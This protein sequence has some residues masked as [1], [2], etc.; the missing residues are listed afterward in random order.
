MT[1]DTQTRAG[2]T[3]LRQESGGSA[4]SGRWSSYF[5]LLS[6]VLIVETLITACFLFDFARDI[7]TTDESLNQGLYPTDCFYQLT[8]EDEVN[9]GGIASCELMKKEFRHTAHQRMLLDIQNSLWQTLGENN[10]TQIFKPAIHLG[11]KQEL[12]QYTHM[13]KIGDPGA[14]APALERVNWEALGGQSSQEGLMRLSP[15][16]EIVVPQDGIY[17]VYSQVYFE[18][19][20]SGR[21]LQVIQYLFKRTA[22][23]PELTVLAKASATQCLN[24]ES[25]VDLYSSHQGALFHLQKGDR[26]SLYVINIDAVRFSPE[27]T[28][29]GAF[30]ID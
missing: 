15:D 16:G 12:K 7:H 25:G 2:Y 13:Q 29:F 24:I 8:A 30:I 26:L 22:L 10:I 27:A 9:G 14:A 11:A 18:T 28:Y 17:F 23:H 19:A 3:D 1:A 6:L 4:Q 20:H 5:L 21:D